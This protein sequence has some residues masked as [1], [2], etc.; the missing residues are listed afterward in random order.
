MVSVLGA[1]A[2]E[3]ASAAV[4]PGGS[5]GRFHRGDTSIAIGNARLD[6]IVAKRTRWRSEGAYARAM[7][8]IASPTTRMMVT[9]ESR[10][11]TNGLMTHLLWNGLFRSLFRDYPGLRRSSGLRIAR[12]L[13]RPR[14]WQSCRR[15]CGRDVAP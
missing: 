13:P 12:P 7:A 4:V 15:T 10:S 14:S 9:F 1:L 2:V 3:G 8:V 11:N 6:A 5:N